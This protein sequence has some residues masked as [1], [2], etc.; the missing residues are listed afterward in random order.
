MFSKL[1]HGRTRCPLGEIS[2]WKDFV[3][4]GSIRLISEGQSWELTVCNY[5]SGEAS[6]DGGIIFT[7]HC[8]WQCAIMGACLVPIAYAHDT[9]WSCPFVLG[10]LESVLECHFGTFLGPLVTTKVRY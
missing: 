4:G 3:P 2:N 10:R 9:Q 6:S 5:R 7:G 1:V 8:N